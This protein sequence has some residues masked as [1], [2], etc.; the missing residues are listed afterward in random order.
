MIGALGGILGLLNSTIAIGLLL[1]GT[2]FIQLWAAPEDT[3]NLLEKI[4]LLMSV[5]A[6]ISTG[7]MMIG[8]SL[9]AQNRVGFIAIG[10]IIEGLCS[11]ALAYAL[12]R[13]MG[14]L[15]P[16]V[17]RIVVSSAYLFIAVPWFMRHAALV[18]VRDYY[19]GCYARPFLSAA[20]GALPLIA[21][22]SIVRIDTWS[23]FA[24]IGIPGITVIFLSAFFLG[25]SA[26]HRNEVMQ[27]IGQMRSA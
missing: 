3:M 9:R 26:H 27:R 10:Q 25:L 13:Y 1:L 5:L 6:M 17:A 4:V 20:L 23:L 16:I 8:R 19:W 11:L 15:G 24:A 22:L 12:Y 14:I 18:G 21:A 7:R 2:Q